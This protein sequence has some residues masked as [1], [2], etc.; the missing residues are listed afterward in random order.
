MSAV[1]LYQIY[2]M[3]QH[4]HRLQAQA[5]ALETSLVEVLYVVRTL[6]SAEH[7]GPEGQGG[8]SIQNH[9]EPTRQERID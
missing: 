7:E 3:A 5:N 4:L 6:A 8:H 1:Q 2:N 9:N